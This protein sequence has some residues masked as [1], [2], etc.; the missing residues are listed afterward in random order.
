MIQSAGKFECC[1]E[2]V[3]RMDYLLFL[4]RGYGLDPERKWPLIFFLHG[5]GERGDDLD[6][7]LRHGI[8][9]IVEQQTDLA[10]VT[11]SPQCP[12]NTTWWMEHETVFALLE[13]VLT[14]HA[15]D[16]DRV[17]LTGMS[18]GGYGAWYLAAPH[19]HCFAAMAPI[20]GGG[21]PLCGFPER[22]SAL[23]HLPVWAFHGAKDPVVAVGET[24]AMVQ[25]LRGC[26]G[27]VRLTIYPEA[28]HD[29]W[30]ATYNNPELYEWFLRH[31]RQ[32]DEAA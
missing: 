31:S 8:P 5:A 13:Q 21:V 32:P 28:A 20:C 23:A 11:L 4:P 19:P 15:V 30:T 24:E 29:S 6:L 18:M 2:K 3:L 12:V 26:G 9:K 7:V 25:A 16:R 27:D 22:V 1:H 10:F 17:Y 14:S